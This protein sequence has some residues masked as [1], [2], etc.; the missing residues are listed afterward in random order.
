MAAG[1]VP[2]SGGPRAGG[3]HTAGLA[4]TSSGRAVVPALGL[5]WANCVNARVFLSKD[6]GPGGHSR[7]MYDGGPSAA[8]HAAVAAGAARPPPSAPQLRHMQI[9]FSPVLPQRRCAYVVETTGVRGLLPA[10]EETTVPD[11]F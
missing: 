2:R 4:L 10:E 9:V 11:N 1:P 7:V 6:A 5:A 8:M 3:S